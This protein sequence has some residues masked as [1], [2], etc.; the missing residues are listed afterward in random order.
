MYLLL[1]I[2]SLL[3]LKHLFTVYG[4]RLFSVIRLQQTWQITEK[5]SLDAGLDRSDTIGNQVSPQFNVN[6]PPTSGSTTDFT[7][8]SA[9]AAHN[10]ED[11]SWS[12]RFEIR[13]GDD[14][15][16][17]AIYTGIYSALHEG[18]SLS[19]GLQAFRAESE[20]GRDETNADLRFGLAYRPMVS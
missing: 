7:A 3:R 11:W 16:K 15:D 6:V 12:G 4:A 17:I 2:F 8:V 10:A 1:K 13:N 19:A 18:L 5:W 14:E 9:G 20:T